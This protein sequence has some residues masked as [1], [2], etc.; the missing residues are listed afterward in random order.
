MDKYFA[1]FIIFLIC[2]GIYV[3]YIKE[4]T[5]EIIFLYSGAEQETIMLNRLL[6]NDKYKVTVIPTNKN[7]DL[8][9]DLSETKNTYKVS[10]IEKFSDTIASNCLRKK[11]KCIMCHPNNMYYNLVNKINVVGYPFKFQD[12]VPQF[13]YIRDYR[14][15]LNENENRLRDTIDDIKN[16]DIL[17][18]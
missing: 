5:E 8:N 3:N 11:P 17:D 2:I 4:N 14:K 13:Q 6:S 1:Y 18:N 10:S 12:F 15:D 7:V 9:K 16:Q